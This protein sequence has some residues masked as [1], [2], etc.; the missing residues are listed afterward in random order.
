MID[1]VFIYRDFAI[2]REIS[3]LAKSLSAT[4]HMYVYIHTYIQ[5]YSYLNTD[6]YMYNIHMYVCMLL[7]FIDIHR[8]AL[9]ACGALKA[10]PLVNI[11]YIL[12]YICMYVLELYI[13]KDLRFMLFIFRTQK[14]SSIENFAADR[15]CDRGSTS[16][17]D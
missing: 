16:N 9:S 2:E 12:S 15:V 14:I 6:V 11:Q 13:K 3:I 5:S 17:G 8:S 10:S 1:L 7:T 4:C